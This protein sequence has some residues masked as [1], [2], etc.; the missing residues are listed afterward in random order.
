MKIRILKHDDNVNDSSRPFLDI[1]DMD[2]LFV[3]L[4]CSDGD[5]DKPVRILIDE[6]NHAVIVK[7]G[8]NDRLS[9]IKDE[10]HNMQ[11][12]NEYNFPHIAKLEFKHINKESCLLGIE[13]ILPCILNNI[14]IHNMRQ[15]S[16][17]NNPLQFKYAFFQI[18]YTL[19][20]LQNY[21]PAFKH[22]D[23]KADNIL[24]TTPPK[25]DLIYMIHYKDKKKVFHL[26]NVNLYVKLIDFEL[27][28]CNDYEHLH[29]DSVIYANNILQEDFGLTSEQCD[30]FDIHLFIMDVM[31]NIQ[32]EYF[33]KFVYDF[34]SKKYFVTPH[35]TYQARLTIDS[36]KE[37]QE[38]LTSTNI[39]LLYDM[40]SHPYFFDLRD[41]TLEKADYEF[42]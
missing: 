23:F 5:E 40:L 10:I 27:A 31:K 1:N 41:D 17:A 12:L 29:S 20:I 42:S 13:F 7:F 11:T 33:K 25:T 2:D 24:L 8:E 4:I 32:D 16:K 21:F 34:F 14:K 37:I 19:F 6:H 39:N 26:K 30:A 15:L 28:N 36:Q 22:N 3:S 35:I 18:L 38:K 9:S